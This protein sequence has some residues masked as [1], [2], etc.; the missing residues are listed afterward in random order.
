MCVVLI[1]V[2]SAVSCSRPGHAPEIGS[3]ASPRSSVPLNS[4][5]SPPAGAA[6][7]YAT[8]IAEVGAYLDLWAREGPYT[9]AAAYLVPQEQAPTDADTS[10]PFAAAVVLLSG[11]V[12]SY[13]PWAWVSADNFT[14]DVAMTL[15]FRGDAASAAWAEGRNSELFTFTRPNS[16]TPYRMYAATGP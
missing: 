10:S 5:T 11:A 13:R 2:G 12:D 14:L 8:A 4:G 9:A 3:A 6:S 15:H 16:E 7:A 1:A